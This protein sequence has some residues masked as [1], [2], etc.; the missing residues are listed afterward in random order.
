MISN[1]LFY[2]KL[3]T[4]FHATTSD[5]APT[6]IMFIQIMHQ[7]FVQR[8]KFGRTFVTF[9]VE[10]SPND[11][12][13]IW[14]HV[15]CVDRSDFLKFLTKSDIETWKVE[16]YFLIF[17]IKYFNYSISVVFLPSSW[18]FKCCFSFCSECSL[19]M[20]SKLLI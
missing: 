10:F 1:M 16:F 11:F 14:I 12:S 20:D 15:I 3:V 18:T 17:R 8:L 9:Q 2:H 13:F 19:K 4:K 7:C 6:I 5:I